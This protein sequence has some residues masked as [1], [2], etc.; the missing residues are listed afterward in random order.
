LPAPLGSDIPVPVESTERAVDTH[1][2]D[3]LLAISNLVPNSEEPCAP[4]SPPDPVAGSSRTFSRWE[5]AGLDTCGLAHKQQRLTEEG[6]SAA[7][8]RVMTESTLAT[9][10]Q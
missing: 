3:T 7:T 4:P 1:S 6:A 10:R 8:I 5:S 9:T 2:S